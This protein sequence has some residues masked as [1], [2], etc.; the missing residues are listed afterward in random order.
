[1]TA[2]FDLNVSRETMERLEVFLELL[3]KWN[4]RINLVSK[5][6]IAEAWDRHILDSAQVFDLFDE[7]I[8]H[9]VDF[10]SGGGFPG[11]VVAILS[12]EWSDPPSVSLVE[13]DT[14][15]SVFLQN[16]IRE[17]QIPVAVKNSRIEASDPLNADVIS[18]RALADLTQLL[19]LSVA[20]LGENGKMVFLKGKNWQSEVENARSEWNFDLEIV[21]SRTSEGSVILV[22]SGVS[23]V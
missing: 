11:L 14:R 15:K 3:E 7:G 8:G 22:I 17:L 5:N 23:S 1:M 20:H 21:K 16:V 13:S 2:S 10:G 4:P 9:W 12:R 6:T 19:S 18:A